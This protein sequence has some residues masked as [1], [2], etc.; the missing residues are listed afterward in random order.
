MI[1]KRPLLRGVAL[2][3]ALVTGACAVGPGPIESQYAGLQQH[4]MA[5]QDQ[6]AC[7]QAS[8]LFTQVQLERM[9]REAQN[10]AV[11]AGVL[12][13]VAG[14]AL[15][16]AAVPRGNTYIVARPSYGYRRW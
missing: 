12:G 5:T 6:G 14:A 16:A 10:N 13:V 1:F 4:C 8:F 7:Q 2:A 15:G 9:Q 3:L 11:A